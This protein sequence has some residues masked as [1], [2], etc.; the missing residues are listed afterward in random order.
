MRLH[1]SRRKTVIAPLIVTVCTLLAAG[2]TATVTVGSG[3]GTPGGSTATAT[4]AGPTATPLPPQTL[5]WIE[6]SG[7]GVPDVW[8][9][10]AG[11]PVHQISHNPSTDPCGQSALGSSVF[12]P[13]RTH[14]VVSGG[15]GCGDGPY[16]AYAYVIDV[17]SGSFTA[18]PGSNTLT[19]PRSV[20][21]L[22]NTTVWLA[23]NTMETYTLG[24]SSTQALPE[25]PRP[26]RPWCAAVRS[27]T[28]PPRTAAAPARRRQPSIATA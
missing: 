15:A 22:N 20:G 3:T 23:N 1:V 26:S 2:G 27:S 17:S 21:W 19:D 11:G 5:A 16:H 13:D 12:S 6:V 24:A 14:L 8:G 18:I 7:T 9:S 28:S 10:I 25:P 4:H